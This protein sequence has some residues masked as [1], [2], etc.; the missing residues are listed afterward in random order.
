MRCQVLLLT[1]K[2]DRELLR[3]LNIFE[4]L[5]SVTKVLQDPGTSMADARRLFDGVIEK[6]SLLRYR[7]FPC[8]NLVDNPH[9]ESAIVKVQ[10]CEKK[11]L[12]IGDQ[13]VTQHLQKQN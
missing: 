4:M 13:K 5:E 3:F 10:M 9:F 12:S 2:E 7:L 8:S 11:S 6:F 1:N